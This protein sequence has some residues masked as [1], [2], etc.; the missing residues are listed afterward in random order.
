M[1][2]FKFFMIA[3]FLVLH[4]YFI[5]S[6]FKEFGLEGTDTSFLPRTLILSTSLVFMV[7]LMWPER[8][9]RVSLYYIFSYIALYTALVIMYIMREPIIGL[10]AIFAAIFGAGMAIRASPSWTMTYGPIAWGLFIFLLVW[11]F[12]SDYKSVDDMANS[13]TKGASINESVLP[14]GYLSGESTI[15]ASPL[16]VATIM[17]I[18][19]YGYYSSAH[20]IKVNS[21]SSISR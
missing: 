14:V 13:I 11:A 10:L 19:T 18:F 20:S 2:M 21:M 12:F 17:G 6:S 1:A 8:E 5:T 7:S 15:L 3:I 9:T 16:V 4:V